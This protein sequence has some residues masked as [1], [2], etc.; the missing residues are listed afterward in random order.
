MSL[1]NVA[2]MVMTMIMVM[3]VM[4]LMIMMMVMMENRRKACMT[5]QN[6]RQKRAHRV[7]G[8]GT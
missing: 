5:L 7:L 3:M 8:N 6:A 4:M 2:T 1:Q